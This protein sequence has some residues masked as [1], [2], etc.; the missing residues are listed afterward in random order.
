MAKFLNSYHFLL[1]H[2]FSCN[3]KYTSEN[4]TKMF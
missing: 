4:P 2:H 3:D 1:S